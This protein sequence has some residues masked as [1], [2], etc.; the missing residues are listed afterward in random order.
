MSQTT[1][2][3]TSIYVYHLTEEQEYQLTRARHLADL[4]ALLADGKP[5]EFIDL[6]RDTL[7]STFSL[8]AELL[9]SATPVFQPPER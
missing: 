6:P 7:C 8:L 2:A 4:L 1:H 5:K 9:A 3:S